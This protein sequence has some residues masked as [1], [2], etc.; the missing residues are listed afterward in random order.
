[1]SEYVQLENETFIWHA[2]DYGISPRQS[3]KIISCIENGIINSV[4]VVANSR[5]HTECSQLLNTLTKEIK[6]GIHLNL[7]EGYSIAPKEELPLIVNEAGVMKRTFFSL[8]L[9]SFLPGR[10]ESKKQ[11]KRELMAQINQF[12]NDYGVD[13]VNIDSHNHFHMIPIVCEALLEGL[14]ESEYNIGTIRIP[15]EPLKPYFKMKRIGILSPINLVK[16][17][18]LRM[19]ILINKGSLKEYKKKRALFCGI[20]FTGEMTLERTL[21]L[22]DPFYQESG[23]RAAKVEV[24]FH[25]GGLETEEEYLNPNLPTFKEFY[26][27]KKRDLEFETCLKLKEKYASKEI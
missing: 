1:M 12:V 23:K 25:P 8:L 19:L 16:N 15:W 11:I 20:M 3:L 18:V 10:T 24:L 14:S 13:I 27:S 9:H 17:Y 26:E 7:L 21:Q 6:V 4:S 22:I 5:F 2:D